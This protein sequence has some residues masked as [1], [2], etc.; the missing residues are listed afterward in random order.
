MYALLLEKL[1]CPAKVYIGSGTM[2][3]VVIIMTYDN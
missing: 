1:G 3:V 2:V